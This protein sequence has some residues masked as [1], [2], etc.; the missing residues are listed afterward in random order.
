MANRNKKK[1]A[2]LGKQLLHDAIKIKAISS[3]IDAKRD[4][5]L[6]YIISTQSKQEC[7]VKMDISKSYTR[8]HGSMT[9]IVLRIGITST[10]R[11]H[12]QESIFCT[13]IACKH[14]GIGREIVILR[15]K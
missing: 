12:I 11:N 15:S 7:S 3:E 6:V 2:S 1:A 10:Y 5:C 4:H 13:Y 8:T 9:I 14:V